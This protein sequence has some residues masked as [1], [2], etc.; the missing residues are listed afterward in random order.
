M[1]AE[2]FLMLG[3][4]SFAAW[5]GTETLTHGSIFDRPRAYLEAR[6]GFWGD[7]VGCSFC[8]SHWVAFIITAISLATAILASHA[9]V[10]AA[11]GFVVYWLAVTRCSQLLNDLCHKIT[12][13][14]KY[15]EAQ[16]TL[17][18]IESQLDSIKGR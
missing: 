9:P 10:K 15:G 6:G 13:T 16:S 11:W 3:V 8:L 17:D 2:L 4:A 14:P 7:L 1:T 18:E 12:R 5:Q